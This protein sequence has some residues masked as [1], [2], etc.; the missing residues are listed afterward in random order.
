MAH[1]DLK[2]IEYHVKSIL[3][4]LGADLNDESIK[5]TPSRVARMYD[6]VFSG[7]TYSNDQIA[8]LNDKCFK[9]DNNDLVLVKDIDSFSFCEHH[10][11][12]MYNMKVHVAYIPNGK[13]IGLSKIPRIV[14]MVCKRLQLQE[15]IGAD[16]ASILEKILGTKDIM[17]V[18]EGEHSC[19][20]V[21]GIKKPGTKTNTAVVKGLFDKN[22]N[23]RK[24]V[25]ALLKG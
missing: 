15:R 23:L 7:M 13:V 4:I 6:E 21:R 24:E 19:L 20:T 8:L 25:Y 17:V 1:F 22:S 2:A 12:L 16:I 18:I 9:C 11:A 14:E 3:E 5:E 10:M